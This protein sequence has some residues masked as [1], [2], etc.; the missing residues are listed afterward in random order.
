[1]NPAEPM[2]AWLKQ[3]LVDRGVM[4]ADGISRRARPRRCI[5][6]RS[7]ILAGLD[8]DQMAITAIA[9]P[10]PLTALG[11]TLALLADPPRQTWTLVNR[12]RLELDHRATWLGS[13]RHHPAGSGPDG[14]PCRHDVVPEHRCADGVRDATLDTFTTGA[15]ASMP[16]PAAYPD[17]PPF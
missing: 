8:D 11:E 7:S 15:F 1:M 9:D 12:G 17:D 5:R 10:V 6:C 16:A 14:G 2:A 13:H 4:T 3:T